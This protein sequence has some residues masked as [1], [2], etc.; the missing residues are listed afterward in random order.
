MKKQFVT[1]EIALKLKNLGFNEDCLGAFVL[2]TD[3]SDAE[4]EIGGI[5]RYDLKSLGICKAPHWQ[6]VFD[7]FRD[8]KFINIEVMTSAITFY[9]N[10]VKQPKKYQ[11][12]IEDL[13]DDVDYLYHSAEDEI[14]YESYYDARK[15]AIFK[16]LEIYEIKS[17]IYKKGNTKFE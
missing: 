11:F 14:F 3:D 8:V 1:H 7:W 10:D 9:K 15:D 4:L 2:L 12:L 16:T 13:K 6:Q 17:R 5:W